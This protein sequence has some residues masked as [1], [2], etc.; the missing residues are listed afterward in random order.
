[1]KHRKLSYLL[2]MMHILDHVVIVANVPSIC[3]LQILA[4]THKVSA[5]FS[6]PSVFS[7]RPDVIFLHS[8][9]VLVSRAGIN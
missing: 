5:C 7:R 2:F 9:V 3:S 8:C 6:L 1:M 4:S